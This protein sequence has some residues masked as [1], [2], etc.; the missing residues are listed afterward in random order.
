MWER[1]RVTTAA[2]PAIWRNLVKWRASRKSQKKKKTYK[3]LIDARQIIR[4]GW[5][6]GFRRVLYAWL[7]HSVFLTLFPFSTKWSIVVKAVSTHMLPLFSGI[8][9]RI[10]R[11]AAVM[12]ILTDQIFLMPTYA[13]KTIRTGKCRFV[14]RFR[15][16]CT[17]LI[18]DCSAVLK[19][20]SAHFFFDVCVLSSGCF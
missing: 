10:T 12:I 1:D 2:R 5:W 15:V 7:T 17:S 16:V 8:F 6:S 19:D 14:Q 3:N 20:I 18:L 13:A 9:L 4:S 11:D